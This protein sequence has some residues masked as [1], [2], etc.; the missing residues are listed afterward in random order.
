MSKKQIALAVLLLIVIAVVAA[1][2]VADKKFGVI[3]PSPKV[4]YDS[5]VK[6]ETRAEV[7]VDVPKLQGIIQSKLPPKVPA[8]VLPRALPYQAALLAD[9]DYPLNKTDFTLFINEQRLAPVILDQ[10]NRL[11]LPAPL[12]EWFKEK[13]ASVERGKLIRKGE[14]PLDKTFL[15]T[16]KNL[17]KSKK[18]VDAPLHIQGGHLIE[19]ALDNRDGSLFTIAGSLASSLGTDVNDTEI[20][21]YLGMGT[22]IDAVRLQADLDDGKTLKVRVIIE[23]APGS[24]PSQV[25][26]VSMALALGLPY[27]KEPLSKQGIKLDGKA[28][29]KDNVVT[30]DYSVPNFDAVLAKL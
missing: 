6:P 5:L 25:Q 21:G 4:S 1:A 24:D 3:L 16:V 30:G 7:V 19:V 8:W 29:V 22:C 12:N 23:C 15:A 26:M 11:N 9:V 13:M 10:V 14:A 27:A 17:V 2:V 28:D 20:A 18:G